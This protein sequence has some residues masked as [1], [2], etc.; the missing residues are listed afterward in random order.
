MSTIASVALSDLRYEAAQTRKMLERVPADRWDWKPHEK[1][2]SLGQL[3]S[4][5]ARLPIWGQNMTESDHFDFT[6]PGKFA[7]MPLATN[8]TEAVAH[9]DAN[10]APVLEAI[11]AIDDAS[12][13]ATY[14]LRRGDTV[15]YE[16]PRVAAIRYWLS[17]HL[18]HHRGQLSVYLRLL[19]VPV[20]GMYGPSADEK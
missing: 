9:F 19:D 5:I 14:Q 12:A 6:Q 10:L 13:T 7:T 11:G 15:V 3:A 17:N 18:V 1:S 20:P 2:S 16:A 4:H 8:P